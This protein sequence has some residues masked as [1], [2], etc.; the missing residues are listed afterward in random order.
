MNVIARKHSD[1]TKTV[2]I[3]FDTMVMGDGIFINM[4]IDRFL[5]IQT[6]T[7]HDAAP[8]DL[9]EKLSTLFAKSIGNGKT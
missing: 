7:T 6:A 8:E 1:G 4:L 9:G 2:E 3:E 5:D